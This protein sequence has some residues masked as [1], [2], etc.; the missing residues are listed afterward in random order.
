M[1]EPGYTSTDE[2]SGFGLMIAR[3]IA[4]AH[5]WAIR[6]TEREAGGVRFEVTGVKFA[7]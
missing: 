5:G 2:G 1:F 6:V 3:E 4:R 7:D